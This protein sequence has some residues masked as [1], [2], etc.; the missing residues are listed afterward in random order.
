MG[1]Q[2]NGKTSLR[3]KQIL[4]AAFALSAEGSEWSLADIAERVGISKP[5]LYRH[6]ANRANIEEE[7]ERELFRSVAQVICR[8]PADPRSIRK[9]IVDFLR[10]HQGHLYLIIKH[11]ITDLDFNRTLVEILVADNE[12]IASYFARIRDFNEEKHGKVS[13]DLLVNSAT[14]LLASFVLD[15]FPKGLQDALLELAE[16]GL[17]WLPCP[18]D[19]RL[20]ELDALCELSDEEVNREENRILDAIAQVIRKHGLTGTTIEKIAEETGTAKSS[21]YWHY[22]TKHEMMSDLVT[23]ETDAILGF[24]L[25]RLKFGNGLAEQLYIVMNVQAE[26]IMRRPDFAPVFNWMRYES[27]VNRYHAEPNPAS[28]KKF[29]DNLAL[30]EL[31]DR[32]NDKAGKVT[33]GIAVTKW[34]FLL[35]SSATIYGC[36]AG[37]SPEQIRTSVRTTY[38]RVMRGQKE[39][40]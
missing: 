21:L 19:A 17:S 5:A 31:F 36:N 40:A 30:D 18:S 23:K 13:I 15:E 6:Y 9:A 20:R 14:I 11:L 33:K 35:S 38:Y 27:I 3:R 25:D 24:C 8:A 22:R 32:A 37:L 12:T 39:I 28:L 4:E 10:A 34:V 7:M 2:T 26:Y 29:F 16:T 1:D